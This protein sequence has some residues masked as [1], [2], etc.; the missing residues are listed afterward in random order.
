MITSSTNPPQPESTIGASDLHQVLT[1]HAEPARYLFAEAVIQV[2]T[3]SELQLVLT[4]LQ[5]FLP[6]CALT[7]P[8]PTHYASLLILREFTFGTTTKLYATWIT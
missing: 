2:R 1:G 7:I 6:N 5:E 4:V 8:Q 3:P